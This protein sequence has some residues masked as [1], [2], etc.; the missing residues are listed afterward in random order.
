MECCRSVCRGVKQ[1]CVLSPLLFNIF[2]DWVVRRVMKSVGGTGIEIRYS[3][4][5]KELHVKENDRT[6][7][8]L[9]NMLMYA[10]DMAVMDS[11]Y[12]N[13]R[14]F[15]IELDTQLCQVGMMMNVKKTKMMVLNGIIDEPIMI[16][17]EKIEEERSFPYLGVSM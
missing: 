17:G 4:K 1:G 8:T 15:L 3:Q 6:E 16:R 11:D 9:V 14:R 5:K 13:V 7:R 12:G 2:M 10:D